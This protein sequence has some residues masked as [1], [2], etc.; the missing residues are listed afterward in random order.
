MHEQ[1]TLSADRDDARPG[2]VAAECHSVSER[3]RRVRLSEPTIKEGSSGRD[4]ELARDGCALRVR[5]QAGASSRRSEACPPQRPPRHPRLPALRRSAGWG[6]GTLQGSDP[7]FPQLAGLARERCL[8]IGA[9]DHGL[10]L[11]RVLTREGLALLFLDH[12]EQALHASASDPFEPPL[13]HFFPLL[14]RRRPRIP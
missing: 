1:G 7:W 13:V 14:V 9:K 5:V 10:R 4:R 3:T 8:R 6:Q 2:E 11:Q 12:I